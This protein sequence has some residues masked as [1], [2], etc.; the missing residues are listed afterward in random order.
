MLKART[1]NLNEMGDERGK[2]VVLEE[3][4]VPLSKFSRA[5]FIYDTGHG[6]VRGRH[7]NR[8]SDFLLIAVAGSCKIKVDY[9]NDDVVFELS[10]PYTGVYIPKLN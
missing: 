4:V 8:N 6:V 3:G 7:A 5:F 2:L 10:N 1:V 9:G